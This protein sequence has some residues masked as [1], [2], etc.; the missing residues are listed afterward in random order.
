MSKFIDRLKQVIQPPPPPM[1][2]RPKNV[3]DFRPK[4]QLVARLHNY[5]P[6]QI[7]SLTAADAF[8]ISEP[9]TLKN[10]I[11]YGLWLDTGTVEE[12]NKAIEKGADFVVFPASGD[13]LPSD[14]KIGKILKLNPSVT[15]VLLRT[16]NDLP[17]DAVLIDE[18]NDSHS[19]IDWQKLMLSRRFTSMLTKPV[20]VPV[21]LTVTAT[22]LQLIW[23][24]KISGVL[25]D[26]KSAADT[27]VL[28]N[29]RKLINEL[30]Y[31]SPKKPDKLMPILPQAT[32]KPEKL[33]EPDEDDDDD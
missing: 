3:E 9:E 2:F 24:A 27:T 31:P 29:L 5:K 4:I 20:L 26:I 1:G 28:E 19:I 21:S 18:D 15:D 22:E 12:V 7:D 14:K 8:I 25:V 6:S 23:D 13:I 32:A 11:P 10:D 17:L 30:T 16:T 33:E